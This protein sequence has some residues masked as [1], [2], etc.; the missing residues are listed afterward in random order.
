M[1][2]LHLTIG[3]WNLQH[4]TPGRCISVLVPPNLRPPQWRQDT[5]GN[6][7][8]T[9]RVSTTRRERASP[10]ATLKAI[11]AQTARNQ[12][13]RTGVAL[14]AALE[15]ADLLALWAKQSIVVLQP[16]TANRLLDTAMLSNLGRLDEAPSF[17]PDAGETLELWFSTPARSPL[18]LCLGAVTVGGRLRLTFR[19]PR[20]VFSP[21]AARR[22]ADCYRDHVRSVA[23]SC[24]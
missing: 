5:V 20:R 16:L 19:Y 15:R 10:A 4:G 6:F 21:D 1:A 18:S 13:T 9:A 7:S 12:R 24:L 3:D 22:F 23:D 14:I 11:A 17:G 8:V 2:A